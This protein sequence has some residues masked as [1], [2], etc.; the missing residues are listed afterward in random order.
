MSSADKV[1]RILFEEADVRGVVAGLETSFGAVMERSSYPLR[2]QALLGEMLAA[3][4]LLSST[5]KF[6]GRMIL[7]AQGEGSLRLL[8]AEC[9]HHLQ[10]R[11]IARVE[12]ELPDTQSFSE[13]FSQGRLALTIEPANG[14]RYQGVVPMEQASLAAC[15]E[16]YFNR[17]E[18]LPTH[19]QLA[20]DGQRAAGM[21]L[22]VLPTTGG[23]SEDWNRIGVLA[24]TLTQEE[25][26]ALDN[27]AMLYRLFH[28]EKCRL[29][30]AQE[31]EFYCDCSR[32]RCASALQ[33]VGRDELLAAAGE[34]GGHISVDCQFCN[35]VYQFDREDILALTEEQRPSSE[36][37]H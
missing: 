24:D 4:A 3:V 21:L 6:D 17:S 29:Y 27:E 7:Q 5:L 10:V 30:E 23:D 16:D 15:L 36:T 32:E 1:Q 35:A 22:Q 26:L 13:L 14:Q 12:G 19:I 31:L 2:V 8:M 34:Q 11:G 20:C 37:L 33:L 9:S 18:Q 28:Q 25:L